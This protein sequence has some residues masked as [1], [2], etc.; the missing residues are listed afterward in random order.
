MGNEYFS[1]G[2]TL[3]KSADS[4][5]WRVGGVAS[6]YIKDLDGDVLSPD[7]I[8]A[9]IPAF[10]ANRGP[11]NVRGG[12]I[13]LNHGLWDKFLKDAI[14]RLNLTAQ[15][16]IEMLSAISLPLGRVTKI[17]VDGSGTTHWEGLLSPANPI[18]KMIWT[19][20]KEGMVQLG[21][22]VGGQILEVVRG[23]IDGIGQPC[24]LISKIRLDEL[25]IT[26]NPAYRLT[27]GEA[28]GNGAYIMA[29]AKSLGGNAVKE[30]SSGSWQDTTTGLERG[31]T[32]KLQPKVAGSGKGKTIPM[33]TGETKVGR[34]ERLKPVNHA[35][36][37]TGGAELPTDVWG[38]TIGQLTKQL[39][40]CVSM[41]KAAMGSPETIKFLSDSAYGLINSPQFDNPDVLNL[42]RFLDQF[43]KY[44]RDL[45]H[46]D[47]WQAE[48]TIEAMGP[49]LQKSLDGFQERFPKELM[50][51]P[52]RPPG[53]PR[54]VGQSVIFPDQYVTY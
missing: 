53:S 16:Q 24:T 19:M 25:S 34:T 54:P 13:R 14:A 28:I 20:L 44:A 15:E 49:D 26:D 18:A 47:P 45:P 37:Q 42:A 10:M 41:D 48:G 38:L 2:A 32:S 51:A 46:M 52:L 3:L 17:W 27:R 5:G 1:F 29:L 39:A 31:L 7:A 33:D 35:Q 8:R 6:A 40:K 36:S 43:A 21:V 11:D 50:K 12:P 22:S 4:Q 30:A 23:A 9:A